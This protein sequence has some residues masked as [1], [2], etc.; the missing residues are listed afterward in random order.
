MTY[1]TIFAGF[2]GQGILFSGKVVAYAGMLEGLNVSHLP[3]YGPEMRGGTAN[4][5]V[6]VSDEPVASPL[7]TE[8]TALVV[9]NGPS[10][11][12]FEKAVVPG[13]KIF[14]D[15]TLISR[16]CERDDVDVYTIPA[17]Q[18][19][20]DMGIAKLANMIIVGKLIKETNMFTWEQLEGAITKL[21]PASKAAMLESN[22]KALRAGYEY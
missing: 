15:S 8:P 4:C 19:A 22:I 7:I 1:E 10:L 16:K 18:M 2:G 3:S 12:K 17:T 6:I 14:I 13:G 20:L 21:V 5:S 9:M 11:D